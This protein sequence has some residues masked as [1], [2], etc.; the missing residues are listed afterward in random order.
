MA[1]PAHVPNQILVMVKAGVS[2]ED[3]NGAIEKAGGRNIKTTSNGRLTAILIQAEN[4]QETMEQLKKSN[5]FD[6]VQLN[7]ESSI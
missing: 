2:V 5:Y 1:E 4:M 3:A 7:Y 6:A